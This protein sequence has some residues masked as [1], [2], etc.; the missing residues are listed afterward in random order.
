MDKHKMS[1]PD[2]REQLGALSLPPSDDLTSRLVSS[3]RFYVE[4][5]LRSDGG[6]LSAVFATLYKVRGDMIINTLK[7]RGEGVFADLTVTEISR[8]NEFTLNPSAW[9]QQVGEDSV[10]KEYALSMKALEGETVYDK[11]IKCPKCHTRGF[12]EVTHMVQ[13]RSADEGMNVGYMC[14]ANGKGGEC[15]SVWES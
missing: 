7:L 6:Q 3:V 12:A 8:L 10:R 4:D 5:T 1:E 9:T 14:H 11:D 2:L 13:K 15:G